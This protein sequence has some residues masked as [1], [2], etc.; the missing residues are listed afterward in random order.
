MILA[1]LAGGRGARLKP[2]TNYTPKPMIKINNIP[3]LEYLIKIY[4]KYNLEKIYLLTGYK[5]KY[6]KKIS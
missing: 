1:I 2:L 6:K 4:S 5:K 3:F